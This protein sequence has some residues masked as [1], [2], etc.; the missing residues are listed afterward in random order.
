[1]LLELLVVEKFQLGHA[2]TTTID[3]LG[4]IK[5]LHN[6]VNTLRNKENINPNIKYR[7]AH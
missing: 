3:L 5:E 1:M 7:A 4:I 6:E 2:A